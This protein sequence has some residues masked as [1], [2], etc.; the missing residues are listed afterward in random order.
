MEYIAKISFDAFPESFDNLKSGELHHN[1]SKYINGQI[2]EDFYFDNLGHKQ[3][4]YVCYYDN[5]KILQECFYIDGKLEGDFKKYYTDGHLEKHDKYKKGNKHGVCR[6][7]SKKGFC[8]SPFATGQEEVVGRTEIIFYYSKGFQTT[9]KEII[10][11]LVVEER[12]NQ[13]D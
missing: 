4:R 2:H 9:D 10:K 3:G 7:F 12:F 1:V 6:N 11:R 8:F 13:N 5:G